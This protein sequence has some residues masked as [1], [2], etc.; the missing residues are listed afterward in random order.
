[1]NKI[2]ERI[3]DGADAEQSPSANNILQKGKEHDLSDQIDEPEVMTRLDNYFRNANSLPLVGFEHALASGQQAIFPES[4]L[5][6]LEI[7]CGK[8]V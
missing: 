2:V 4:S 3:R 5:K 7:F 1:M 8:Y 6:D